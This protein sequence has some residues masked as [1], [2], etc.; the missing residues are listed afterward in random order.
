MLTGMWP[1]TNEMLRRF[2]TDPKKNPDGWCGGNWRSKGYD[3]HAFFPEFPDYP[4][5]GLEGVGD[6]RINYRSVSEDF[7]RITGQ[8]RPAAIITFSAAAGRYPRW[9]LERVA[10]NLD[11]WRLFAH[12][13]SQP[14]P[15]PPDPDYP[16][17]VPRQSTL[18]LDAI[19][20][21]VCSARIYDDAAGYEP[22]AARVQ[23]DAGSFVSEFIGYHG[24]WYQALHGAEESPHRCVAAGHVHVG[25]PAQPYAGRKCPIGPASAGYRDSLRRARRAAAITIECVIDH[26]A[27]VLE[28]EQHSGG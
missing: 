25:T 19:V 12:C 6:F 23:D 7:W 22:P 3:L 4:A 11:A 17:N 16:P 2:S 26:V 27:A 14:S 10:R 28:A 24:V 1:P 13:D 5:G 15:C 20:E 8:L 18:P 21:S 9:I